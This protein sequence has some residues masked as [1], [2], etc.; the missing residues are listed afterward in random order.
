M[1]LFASISTTDAKPQNV[2]L[3]K[4]FN[5]IGAKL[6]AGDSTMLRAQ[7]SKKNNFNAAKIERYIAY[8]NDKLSAY[9]TI[10]AEQDNDLTDDKK[11]KIQQKINKHNQ[12][13]SKYQNFQ[14]ATR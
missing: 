4:N 11:D 2:K 3:S 9:N 14:K 1:K 13:R 10:L 12:Q 6:L 8:I 7:N 5:L